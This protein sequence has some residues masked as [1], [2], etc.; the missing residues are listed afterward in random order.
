M[1]FVKNDSQTPLIFSSPVKAIFTPQ[2]MDRFKNSSTCNE[3]L[4][5]IRDL[6]QSVVSL[7]ISSRDKLFR[8]S[9]V[10]SKFETLMERLYQLVDE[11][12]P[13]DQPMRFGNKAFRDW[14]QKA[15]GC[16]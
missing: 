7:P 4:T 10:V 12:P 5:F 15:S 1:D 3:L 13:I 9:K 14:H 2:D 8:V 11:I 16:N 6:A